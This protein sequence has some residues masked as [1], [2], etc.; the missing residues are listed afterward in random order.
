MELPTMKPIREVSEETGLSY[1]FLRGLIR[2]G[3]IFYVQ[4]GRKFLINVDSLAEYLNG[5]GVKE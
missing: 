1:V 5:K 2:D 3:K 4:A